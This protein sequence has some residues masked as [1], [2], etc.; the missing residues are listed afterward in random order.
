MTFRKSLLLAGTVT[1]A[2]LLPISATADTP[3]DQL[4][5]AWNIDAI[6]TFDPAQIGEV[7]TNELITNICDTLVT[8]DVEDESRVVPL[9]AE[10]WTVSDDNKVVTFTLRDGLAHPSGNP[11][12]AQDM[13]WSMKRVLELEFGNAASLT[14]W[15]FTKENMDDA[16]QALDDKTFQVTLQDPYPPSLILL[17]VMAN[18]VGMALDSAYLEDKEVDGDRANGYLTT[19]TA[20]VG[21]YRLRQW[22]AGEVAVL[23]ANPEYWGGQPA[24][25]RIIVRHVPEASAQRLLIEKGDIDVARDI[26]TP[27]DLA[28]LESNEDL[29]IDSK[30]IHQMIYWGFNNADPILGDDRVREALR[31]LVD[32]DGLGDTV[33]RY[34]GVPR[35]TMVPLGAFAALDEEEGSPY[36]LDLDKARSLLDEAGHGDGF[37]IRLFIGTHAYSPPIAQHI[38]ENASKIGVEISIEQMANAELFSRFRGRDFDSVILGWQT[39]IPDA[40]G[41]ASRHAINPDNSDEAKLTMY[42]TWRASWFREEF[43]AMVDEAVFET[44]PDRRIELYRE[45]QMRHMKEGPFA[46]MFQFRRNVVVR[47]EVSAFPWHAL[48]NFYHLIEKG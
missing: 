2:S 36:S 10:S 3:A 47:D 21:P 38:Q 32:Y 43:N 22:D 48:R 4:V 18:R 12:T 40:H 34:V 41:M 16:F 23:E 26:T 6:S 27:N 33:M 17:A 46:Y 45:I 31:Y 7:V 37:A 1:L 5:M 24:M 20:C 8:H 9:L 13:E 25:R 42:P 35:N 28:D 15:G 44:D 14:Q 19:N 11:V 39:G 29:T 30:L